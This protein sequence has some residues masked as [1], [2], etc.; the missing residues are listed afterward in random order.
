MPEGSFDAMQTTTEPFQL[1]ITSMDP[2]MMPDPEIMPTLDLNLDESFSWEMISLGLEEPMPMQEAI[3]ELYVVYSFM[4]SMS[5]ACEGRKFTLKQSTHR[6]RCS[7]STDFMP[8]W[9]WL[10]KE[11]HPFVSAI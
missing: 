11:G 3:D 7:I 10:V 6:Y 9:I 2:G 5:N 8:R 1:P 4:L